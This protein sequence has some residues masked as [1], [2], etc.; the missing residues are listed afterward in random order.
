MVR[1]RK[2]R[3]VALLCSG[4]SVLSCRSIFDIESGTLA[5]GTSS[6]E[7]LVTP[8]R[9][10][11]RAG[12]AARAERTGGTL[13]TGGTGGS[14]GESGSGGGGGS[15]GAAGSDGG[16]SA[17]FPAGACADCIARSCA[18]QRDAC[19]FPLAQRACRVGLRARATTRTNA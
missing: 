1:P 17:L 7:A 12:L 9:T 11:A 19:A 18:S 13:A 5:G 3:F 6:G 15:S 4:L 14:G 16:P 8:G 2:R 10:T